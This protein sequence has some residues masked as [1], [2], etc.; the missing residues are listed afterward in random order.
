MHAMHVAKGGALVG[1]WMSRSV[2]VLGVAVGL[3]MRLRPMAW[4][5]ET[6]NEYDPWFNFRCSEYLWNHGVRAFLRW[7]D[8]D[9]WVPVGRA[10]GETTYPCFMIGA[11]LVH[12]VLEA[13][14]P[15]SMTHYQ[16]CCLMPVFCFVISCYLLWRISGALFDGTPWAR[17]K[18]LVGLA[19]FSLSGGILEKTVTGA[20]DYEGLSLVWVL[21]VVLVYGVVDRPWV[22]LG[23]L[24]SLF[25]STWGGSVFTDLIVAASEVTRA[26]SASV[27]GGTL[28]LGGISLIAGV[29][30]L[31][32][33]FTSALNTGMGVRLLGVCGVL[34]VGVLRYFRGYWR[35]VALWGGVAASVAV[36]AGAWACQSLGFE[37]VQGLA[38]E[39]LGRNKLYNMFFSQRNHPLVMSI[40]EHRPP[41]V[42]TMVYLGGVFF[43]GVP[44]A[45][46]W[47]LMKQSCQKTWKL[48]VAVFWGC[49]LS[50]AMFLKMERFAF[51]VSPFL[52]LV[53]AE[54][55]TDLA[56]GKLFHDWRWPKWG[57]VCSGLTRMGAVAVFGAHVFYALHS[58]LGLSSDVV[59]VL[60]GE[61]RGKTVIIDDF[62]EAAMFLK[63]NTKADS[64]VISWWDYG[65]QI[66]GMAKRATVVDNNTNNFS[67]IGEVAGLF[68][69]PE[70]DLS[71]KTPLIQSIRSKR[72]HAD[73]FI[74][75]V[76]GHKAKYTQADICKLSWMLKISE[77][78]LLDPHK[79]Y[80]WT[81]DGGSAE[82][83]SLNY[84]NHK[85]QTLFG[86][87]VFISPHLKESL[88]YKLSFFGYDSSIRL[89]N[90]SLFFETLN[91][92]VRVYRLRTERGEHSEPEIK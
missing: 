42:G 60:K 54:L 33:T 91:G 52:S 59:I 15:Y 68:A 40:S 67:R 35:K 2:M 78:P 87:P 8:E 70:R 30:G 50:C 25:M 18:K 89:T 45:A 7:R 83:S 84:L 61:A 64:V 62:R 88:L 73:I 36:G 85:N 57:R 51:L 44:L 20:F 32:F 22:E 19:M 76:C 37:R 74:Y 71:E 63:N 92:V 47:F 79:Y 66:T 16:V 24:Q 10:V 4:A 46:P 26:R 58:G 14:L 21:G 23:V 41:S 48:R 81:E 49:V 3:W 38:R 75:A 65:Y 39:S 56:F 11:N 55:V 80:F 53:F 90:L 43:F 6:I 29:A 5:G 13:V 28:L 31:V 34:G 12:L 17:E 82:M 27:F 69:G 1:A 77:N 9:T 72:V 86:K